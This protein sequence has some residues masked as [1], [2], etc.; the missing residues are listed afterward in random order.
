M[1]IFVFVFIFGSVGSGDNGLEIGEGGSCCCPA[2][3][4]SI[5]DLPQFFTQFN[6]QFP[7]VKWEIHLNLSIDDNIFRVE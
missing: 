3:Y 4:I 7:V 5:C 1:R 2:R 6:I